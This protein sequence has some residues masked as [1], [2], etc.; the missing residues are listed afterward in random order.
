MLSY[1]FSQTTI[2][3][4]YLV[5]IEAYTAKYCENTDHPEIECNG[6]CHLSK[7]L[8]KDQ[9]NK[10]PENLRVLTSIN[11]FVVSGITLPETPFIPI[12]KEKS[13]FYYQENLL[14]RIIPPP[15]LPPDLS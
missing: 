15:F 9:E 5:D 3:I 8:A 12:E 2:L 10:N 4:E 13:N 6:K 7:E 14:T 11:F 1:T